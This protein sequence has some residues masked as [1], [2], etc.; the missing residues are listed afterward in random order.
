MNVWSSLAGAAAPAVI[1]LIYFLRYDAKKPEPGGMVLRV[2]LGGIAATVPLLAFSLILNVGS[3]H[4]HL[5]PLLFQAVEAFVIAGLLEESAKLWVVRR[6]AYRS[7]YFDEIM[8][9]IVYTITASLGFAC[10]ENILFV[11]GGTWQTAVARALTAVPFHAVCSGVMG[12]Y[13]GKAK[14]SRT[15]RQELALFRRGLFTAVLLHGTYDFLIFLS[16]AFG[17]L[18]AAMVVPVIYFTYKR[19]MKHIGLA[20]RKDHLAGRDG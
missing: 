7:P 11:L 16:P 1:L 17:S 5:P 3:P 14:F 12:Y 15:P 9:G 20:L 4:E 18:F 6:L 10:L 13:V 19:L 8:D 2:F